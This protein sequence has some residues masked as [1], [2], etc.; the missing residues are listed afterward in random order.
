MIEGN[1]TVGFINVNT[2][3]IVSIAAGYKYSLVLDSE[4]KVWATGSNGG[5]LGLGN[6]NNQN[7]FQSVTISGLTSG[8]KI[9]SIA[10]GSGYSFALD[11]NGKVW[12]SGGNGAGQL[13]LGN[14]SS[15]TS[16]QLVTIKDLSPN[17]TIVSISA[18]DFHSIILDSNGKI[19]ASGYNYHGQ[20][21]LGNY[22]DQNS[23]QSVTIPDLSPNAT[24]VS[25]AAGM[26]YSLALDSNGKIWATGNNG[27]GQLGLGNTN[28]QKS[29]QAVTIKGLSPNATIVSI[30]AGY[31]H[32]LALDSDGKVWATGSNNVGELGFGNPDW[33]VHE[34]SFKPVTISGLLS[35]AKITS[36]AAG[37]SHS[38]ALD[39]NG[40]VWAS[41]EN[42]RGQLGLGNAS[43]QS[44]F[45]LVTIPDLVPNAKTVSIAA[46]GDHSFALDGEGILWTTGLNDAGQLGLGDTTNRNVFTYVRLF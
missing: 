10:A 27:E 37:I 41:G 29:F 18:G 15:Q 2:A 6:Y 33:G 20:L 36:I 30:A 1:N 12:A 9:T 38:F 22:N 35:S 5:Q 23:F 17:A 19:W 28:S 16:F 21:G 40:K 25:I 45:Q 7:S 46:G 4:G 11:S 13:G 32:S 24:I 34:T 3:K 26:Y 44:E 8:V 39:S 14:T 43:N 42:Y 31:E